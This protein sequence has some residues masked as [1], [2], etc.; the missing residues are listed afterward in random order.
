MGNGHEQQRFHE[1]S[2]T[3][4]SLLTRW[5]SLD[6]GAALPGEYQLR[7][8]TAAPKSTAVQQFRFSRDAKDGWYAV[9]NQGKRWRYVQFVHMFE[10]D[11]R[12]RKGK[13]FVQLPTPHVSSHPP[14]PTL[15]FK[16]MESAPHVR[17]TVPVPRG[18]R[19]WWI[20][21]L[22]IRDLVV[23]NL[24]TGGYR[25]TADAVNEYVQEHGSH[26]G[27]T[28]TQ[29]TLNGVAQQ[30]FDAGFPGTTPKEALISYLTGAV[31]LPRRK[32][33]RP[34]A[35]ANVAPLRE[36]RHVVRTLAPHVRQ[37]HTT[38]ERAARRASEAAYLNRARI[39]EA[40]GQKSKTTTA[41]LTA[42]EYM[43]VSG[44]STSVEEALAS[45]VD[46]ARITIT[47]PGKWERSGATTRHDDIAALAG[48]IYQEIEQSDRGPLGHACR[49]AGIGKI[50]FAVYENGRHLTLAEKSLGS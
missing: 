20:K 35:R 34:S 21:D 29:G 32:A 38:I 22:T 18:A 25:T 36:R 45:L 17:E 37:V 46:A 43:R 33:Q 24:R 12:S 40:L 10:L 14:A 15:Q 31:P 2:E 47:I 13:E 19:A 7:L 41:P 30:K 49:S 42:I 16:K 4:D 8:K 26:P 9:D 6:E 39:I 48:L 50:I 28:L 23:E 44:R 27:K 3:V 11:K 5:R 1:S